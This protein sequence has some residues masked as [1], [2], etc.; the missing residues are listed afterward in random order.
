[1]EA[2]GGA[3]EAL[4]GASSLEAVCFS[5]QPE[6]VSLINLPEEILVSIALHCCTCHDGDVC[7]AWRGEVH[8]ACA[9]LCASLD[10]TAKIFQAVTKQL[11]KALSIPVVPYMWDVRRLYEEQI[12]DANCNLRNWGHLVRLHPDIGLAIWYH[13]LESMEERPAFLVEERV[14]EEQNKRRRELADKYT[15]VLVRH[16]G[17]AK[18]RIRTFPIVRKQTIETR[19]ITLRLDPQTQAYGVAVKR[20]VDSLGNEVT[21]IPGV[22]PLGPNFGNGPDTIKAGDEVIQVGPHHVRGKYV[23]MMIAMREFMSQ[24]H[25]VIVVA[26]RDPPCNCDIYETVS[27]AIMGPTPIMEVEANLSAVEAHPCVM[28]ELRPPGSSV[29]SA[30]QLLWRRKGVDLASSCL[31]AEEASEQAAAPTGTTRAS[32]RW[33]LA[34]RVMRFIREP[35]GSWSG[36]NRQSQPFDLGLLSPAG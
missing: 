10:R 28:L 12:M 15:A 17:I 26:R 8:I 1:M 4:G 25:V 3:M 21:M 27:A 2:L 13:Q 22:D 11:A 9:K 36:D 31:Q 33:S 7:V 19:A 18:E 16:C 5:L 35:S 32:R 30:K 24:G 14:I 6:T 20:M 34:R 23:E 29:E